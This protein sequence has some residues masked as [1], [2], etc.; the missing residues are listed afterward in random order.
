VGSS[1]CLDVAVVYRQDADVELGELDALRQ[2]LASRAQ[3][4]AVVRAL[5][6]A[7][8]DAEELHSAY[9]SLAAE[10]AAV[11]STVVP[12]QSKA[13][14]ASITMRSSPAWPWPRPRTRP[15]NSTSNGG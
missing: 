2:E 15:S 5:A 1:G 10:T 14:R 9:A 3:E 7:A 12:V 13:P 6:Q 4:A 8:G 11:I